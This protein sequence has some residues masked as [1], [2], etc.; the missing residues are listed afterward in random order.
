MIENNHINPIKFKL[1]EIENCIYAKFDN[2]IYY[3]NLN[4]DRIINNFLYMILNIFVNNIDFI[5]KN[6]FDFMH[7]NNYYDAETLK[8]FYNKI[9]IKSQE[10]ININVSNKIK[11]TGV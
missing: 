1:I 11:R 5:N 10:T 9:F 2:S 4:D 8:I 3:K 7:Y 6:N